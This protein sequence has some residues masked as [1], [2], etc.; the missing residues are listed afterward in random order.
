[1]QVLAGGI[2]AKAQDI[3]ASAAS[4]APDLPMIV[5]AASQI[6]SD[7]NS[8]EAEAQTVAVHAG[9]VEDS[10]SQWVTL[11]EYVSVA[12]IVIALVVLSWYWGLGNLLRP[13]FARIG[14][15]FA[16]D[17]K[18]SEAKLMADVLQA[19]AD[20][21]EL[22]AVMRQDPIKNALFKQHKGQ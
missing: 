10:Q 7:A 20:P 22:A 6:A 12:A 14:S 17:Q 13:L 5:A 15:A 3:A 4:D 11:I 9:N 18:K 2:K 16:S 19:K 21:K 8:I 1:M